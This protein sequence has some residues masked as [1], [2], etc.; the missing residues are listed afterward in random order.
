[1]P[2]LVER[3]QQQLTETEEC[4]GGQAASAPKVRAVDRDA[5]IARARHAA[6]KPL[7]DAEVR[8]RTGEMLR[9]ADWDVSG[10][11]GHQPVRRTGRGAAGGDRRLVILRVARW[12]SWGV[13]S[14][15]LCHHWMFLA[16]HRSKDAQPNS[17]H[18]KLAAATAAAF[19]HGPTIPSRGYRM[20]SKKMV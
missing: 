4:F 17:G 20:S 5:F 12:V 18:F 7:T 6:A 11:E 10:R 8:H 19:R 9:L 13:G 16:D 15:R 14:R 2:A 3:T 1:M